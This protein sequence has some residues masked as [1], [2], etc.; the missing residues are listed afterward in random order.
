MQYERDQIEQQIRE[1]TAHHTEAAEDIANIKNRIIFYFSNYAI[2]AY[3]RGI[4]LELSNP[5]DINH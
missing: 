4:K 2:E 1:L 5:E 3:I